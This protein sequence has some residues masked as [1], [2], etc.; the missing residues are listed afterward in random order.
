MEWMKYLPTWLKKTIAIVSQL[1]FVMLILSG[2]LVIF[3]NLYF[4]PV[5]IVGRSMEPTLF[6]QEFGVMDQNV[7]TLNALDRFDIVIVQQNPNVD[8]YL[9]KRLIGL[10]GETISIDEDGLLTVD[11]IEVAQTF[12]TENGYLE[13]T[14]IN[15]QAMGCQ[16]I[17]LLEDQY[18]VMGDNRGFSTDSRV[19]G[20]I[21]TTQLIGKLIAIEGMCGDNA[22]EED[23]NACS[24]RDFFWPRI[25]A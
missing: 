20:P 14:C 2:G 9:I 6:D 4:I 13:Y 25:Y 18:F 12:I 23:P 8:R 21:T 16:P 10:P 15:D 19:F 7:N 24:Q 11:Q 3:H 5:K 22:N 17:T 1:T